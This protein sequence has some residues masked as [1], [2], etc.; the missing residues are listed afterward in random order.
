VRTV[1]PL[2]SNCVLIVVGE[3]WTEIALL[4]LQSTNTIFIREIANARVMDAEVSKDCERKT[5]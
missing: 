1:L 5:E 4:L 3:K 2:L